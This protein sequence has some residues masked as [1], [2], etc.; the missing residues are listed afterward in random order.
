MAAR[1]ALDSAHAMT[2]AMP[3]VLLFADGS[4]SPKEATCI[5]S[6]LAA[7]EINSSQ[8]IE[9]PRAMRAAIH[10]VADLGEED[11]KVEEDAPAP[12]V[13]RAH[14]PP[15]LVPAFGGA[16]LFDWDDSSDDEREVLEVPER[17]RAPSPTSAREEFTLPRFDMSRFERALQQYERA[18]HPRER[19]SILYEINSALIPLIRNCTEALQVLTLLE[20]RQNPEFAPI[21]DATMK[22]LLL[23]SP[24]LFFEIFD[25]EMLALTP[26]ALEFAIQCINAEMPTE[27]KI[28]YSLLLLDRISS[29]DLI[30]FIGGKLRE[31]DGKH[32]FFVRLNSAAVHFTTILVEETQSA[33]HIMVADSIGGMSAFA[34]PIL[35][36]LLDSYYEHHDHFKKPCYILSAKEPRQADGT[37]CAIFAV[38][39]AEAF[40]LRSDFFDR[41]EQG[42]NA[43]FAQLP[44]TTATKYRFQLVGKLTPEMYKVVQ[45]SQRADL[46][47]V[48]RRRFQRTHVKVLRS[49]IISTNG[50]KGLTLEAHLAGND[51]VEKSMKGNAYSELRKMHYVTLLLRSRAIA[52]PTAVKRLVPEHTV[53]AMRTATA[54]G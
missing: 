19:R 20:K 18:T 51:T 5:T 10:I 14:A 45:F 47:Y 4:E 40:F 30:P 41:V 52:Q 54:R 11:G 21:F 28:H 44:G 25:S 22:T 3:K 7:V 48:S 29:S 43:L 17:P 26:G 16:E 15:R 35:R 27:K 46:G 8:H 2:A 6:A 9:R 32:V 24:D 50:T 37:N 1:L 34:Q 13:K 53:A 38:N 39:D 49:H 33:V 23:F 42:A 31:T 12:S 36:R